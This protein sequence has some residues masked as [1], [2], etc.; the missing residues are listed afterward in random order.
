MANRDTS[1]GLITKVALEFSDHWMSLD[2]HGSQQRGFLSRFLYHG[3]S[4]P[5]G[6]MGR[7]KFHLVRLTHRVITVRVKAEA[8]SI[9]RS[10]RPSKR[11]RGLNTT[12]DVDTVSVRTTSRCFEDSSDISD[13]YLE[14]R[15]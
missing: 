11:R 14:E 7:T 2:H 9:S 13:F 4:E 3:R 12:D 10:T 8:N 1:Y 5:H 15:K 6:R